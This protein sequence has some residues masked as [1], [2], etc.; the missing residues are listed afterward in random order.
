ME[1]REY[2]EDDADGT[3]SVFTRAVSITAARDY[4]PQ[5]VRAWI[6]AAE[7]PTAWHEARILA[8]TCV[9][10]IDGQVDGFIDVDDIGHID[11]LFVEPTRARSGIAAALLGWAKQQAKEVGAYRMS[12]YASIN[13][14]PFFE[15]QGFSCTEERHP[16]VRGVRFTN[17]R[18]EAILGP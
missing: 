10:I 9:A 3:R 14:R 11:M 4:T 6:N 5:Q 1:L 7:E 8:N 17:Y 2:T 12:T 13:A 15:A 16:V 18:M